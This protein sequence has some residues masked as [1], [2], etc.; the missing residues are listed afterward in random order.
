MT[1]HNAAAANVYCAAV[2]VGAAAAVA[3]AAFASVV[4]TVVVEEE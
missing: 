3:V 2:P 4:A 1:R